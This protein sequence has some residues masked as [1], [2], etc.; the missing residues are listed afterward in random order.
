MH[1]VSH[2]ANAPSCCASPATAYSLLGLAAKR[3]SNQPPPSALVLTAA[4]PP[5]WAGAVALQSPLLATQPAGEDEGEERG[6]GS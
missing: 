1:T 4:V 2:S 5:E 3:A 6:G